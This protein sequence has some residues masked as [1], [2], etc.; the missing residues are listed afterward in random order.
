MNL[1]LPF[2]VRAIDK[3]EEYDLPHVLPF[4]LFEDENGLIRQQANDELNEL[5]KRAYLKGSLFEG[6]LSNES[7]NIYFDSFKE[8][9]ER[10]SVKKRRLLEIGC[11]SGVLLKSVSKNYQKAVGIEPGISEVKESQYEIVSG[12]YPDDLEEGNFDTIIHFGVL[13]HIEDTYGFL[14]SHLLKL[15]QEGVV[16]AAVPDCTEFLLEGDISI[17]FHE[18]FS[19]FSET[20]LEALFLNC[21]LLPISIQKFRGMLFIAA[22]RGSEGSLPKKEEHFKEINPII[23]AKISNV[24]SKVKEFSESEIAIYPCLRGINYM[25]LLGLTGVRLIDDS[26]QLIGRLIPGF[27]KEIESFRELTENPPRLIIVTSKTYKDQI[28]KRIQEQDSLRDTRIEIL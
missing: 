21:G 6:S 5:L 24:E 20:S 14:Q 9:V 13:E 12:F 7:G 18:H 25:S 27:S 28:V 10:H 26:S 1:N 17:F 19:Y 22:V 8:F 16:I 23:K 3:D 11:G 4:K 2:Y 15:A